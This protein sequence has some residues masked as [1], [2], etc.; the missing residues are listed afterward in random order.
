MNWNRTKTILIFLFLIINIFLYNMLRSVE[1]GFETIDADVIE[2]AAVFAETRGVSIP[3]DIIPDNRYKNGE[4][5]LF[6]IAS[7]PERLAER[8]LGRN[9]VLISADEKEHVYKYE[10]KGKTLEI[11]KNYVKYVE[12]KTET[13]IKNENDAAQKALSDL[14]CFGIKKKNITIIKNGSKNGRGYL[15]IKPS[16]K[17]YDIDGVKMTVYYDGKGVTEL[18]GEWFDFISFSETGDFLDDITSVITTLKP[19]N[20]KTTEILKADFSYYISKDLLY[21]KYVSAI[22]VYSFKSADGGEI[23]IDARTGEYIEQGQK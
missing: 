3:K 19:P 8:F 18:S 9:S 17:G 22:P 5:E 23:I 20:G 21:G 1:K 4:M 7:E 11:K 10:N 15:E 14:A 16:Y 13:A 6:G 2:N 12:N